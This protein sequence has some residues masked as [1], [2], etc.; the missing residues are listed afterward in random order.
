MARSAVSLFA[1]VLVGGCANQGQTAGEWLPCTFLPVEVEARDT[2]PHC[3]RRSEAGALVV[4]PGAL[5]VL[6][7][8]G[9]DPAPVILG[10]ALHYLNTAG[11]AVPVLPFDNGAD[12]F[13]EGLARTPQGGKLGFIDESL[14]VVIPPSWDFAFPFENGTA[15]VCEG[16]A[17]QPVGDGHE[18]VVGGSWG[19]IDT[20]GEVVVPVVHTREALRAL[21]QQ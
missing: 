12:Y 10:G 13:S 16:C 20:R 8:R 5:D 15:V 4:E 6:A 11:V 19:I 21:R 14:R 9:V 2:L 3:A 18:E 1:I 7:A 17:L